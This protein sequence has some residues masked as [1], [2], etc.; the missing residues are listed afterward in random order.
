MDELE[1]QLKDSKK[2]I[3]KLRALLLT[4]EPAVDFARKAIDTL[5]KHFVLEQNC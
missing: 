2:G 1:E 4:P 3:E 5:H